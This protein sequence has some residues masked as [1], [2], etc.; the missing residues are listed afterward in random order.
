MNFFFDRNIARQFARMIDAFDGEN[1]IRPYDDRFDHKTTDIEWMSELGSDKEDWFVLSAD[2]RILRCEKEL[3]A[4]RSSDI[5][6][7]P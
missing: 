6:F 5:T 7:F 2:A 1:I 4:L 3:L